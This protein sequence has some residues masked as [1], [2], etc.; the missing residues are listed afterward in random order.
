MKKFVEK[1]NCDVNESGPCKIVCLGDSVTQGSFEHNH[2]DY[3]SVYHHL[4]KNKINAVFPKMP[5]Q[6]INAGI[7]GKTAKGMCW[8]I[9]PIWSLSV[10]VSMMLM[11][12]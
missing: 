3:Q 10:L 6:M 4:L 12:R 11:G 8:P 5:V 7:G 9:R 2:F 1:L